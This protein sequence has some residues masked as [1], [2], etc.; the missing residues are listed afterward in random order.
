MERLLSEK[1]V[2]QFYGITRRWLQKKRCTGG[3]PIFIKI[4]KSVRYRISD[5]ESFL[6]AH[7]RSSTSDT[8]HE[9]AR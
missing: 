3:G 5:I 6:E 4:G 9:V 7:R 1:E 2:E 8:G